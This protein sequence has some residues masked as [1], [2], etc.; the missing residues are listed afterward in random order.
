MA[1]D[2]I[3]IAPAAMMM[4]HPPSDWAMGTSDEIRQ[5]ADTLDAIYDSMV[6]VYVKRTGLAKDEVEKLVDATTWLTA[7]DAVAKGF[8]DKIVDRD[9]EE[10]PDEDTEEEQEE[11][12]AAARFRSSL[13]A[14]AP[15]GAAKL[16]AMDFPRASARP[17]TTPAAPPPAITQEDALT[18][19]E[20]RKQQEADAKTIAELKD[21]VTSAEKPVADLLAVTG[22]KSAGEALAVVT[23]LKETAAKVPELQA[24]IA[25][26]DAEAKKQAEERQATEIKAM[27]DEAGKDG[28]LTPAKRQEIDAGSNAGLKAIVSSPVTLKAYLDSLTKAVATTG[29][30]PAEKPAGQ[31]P[32]TAGAE[33]SA[34]DKKVIE[35]LNLDPILYALEKSDP[36][37]RLVAE[38]R[39]RRKLE[40]EAAA[41]KVAAEKK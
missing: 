10:E 15:A 4:V 9:D 36:S 23:A 41:K 20:Y 5:V 6:D 18:F 28:R 37:G 30:G 25:K 17:L 27:L 14:N 11:D 26:R 35:Q 12:R 38:E 2:E 8:A 31:A 19:D 29:S 16:L 39:E 33:L 21:G 22:Q 24:E 34:E 7:K 40:A 32:A 3:H 13:I 1:G